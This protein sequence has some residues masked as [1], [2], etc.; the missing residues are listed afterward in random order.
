M[1]KVKQ[2]A[3]K[4]EFRKVFYGLGIASLLIYIAAI[5][6]GLLYFRGQTRD[7]IIASTGQ[8]LA[9][10]TQHQYEQ[11]SHAQLQ[12]DAD[13]ID[14]ALLS[15]EI[16]GVIAL[17][18]FDPAEFMLQQVPQS[19]RTAV[20]DPVDITRLRSDGP[21][22]RYY[23]AMA[24]SSLFSDVNDPTTRWPVVEVL[25]PVS[26]SP[27]TDAPVIQYWLDGT[28][29]TSAF[30]SLDRRLLIIGGSMSA[31]GSAIYL[32]LFLLAR[33]RLLL[34]ARAL[35]ERNRSLEAANRELAM[36]ARTSAVGS[37]AA[38][39]FH[40][41][42]NP[43]AGLKSYLRLTSGDAEAMEL[44]ERMQQLVNETMTTLQDNPAAGDVRLDLE[45]VLET[46]RQRLS[47]AGQQEQITVDV[48]GTGKASLSGQQVQL[49]ILILRNLIDNAVAA[50]RPGQHVHV[51]MDGAD[52]G[53]HVRVHDHGHGIAEER[54]PFLF[55]PL[56]SE[57][58]GGS[59]IGLALCSIIARQ[60][61]AQ[62]RLQHTSCNGSTFHL[63]IPT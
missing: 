4:A 44:A 1:A 59:G 55:K 26:V 39:L 61:P 13:L 19:V 18:L 14:L 30:A 7:Q 49:L 52:D 36:L 11:T 31:A 2:A 47:G 35:A 25:V 56:N 16:E 6:S 54:I 28:E 38:N 32:L 37:V 42:K 8:L 34:M 63:H 5:A 3:N 62:L 33:H 60:L 17:R 45:E 57:K 29:V 15:S 20:L 41:L 58:N 50:S 24:A 40:G 51:A 10:F 9:R 22:I 48:S 43:L 23:P 27:H 46:V 21:I 53:L 12:D